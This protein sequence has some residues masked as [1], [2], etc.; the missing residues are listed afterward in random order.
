MN[1]KIPKMMA[2]TIKKR[3]GV[4]RVKIIDAQGNEQKGDENDQRLVAVFS[5]DIH[6]SKNKTI[7]IIPL[8]SKGLEK[9]YIFHVP[10]FFQGK[11]GKAKCEQIRTLTIERFGER[12]GTLTDKEMNEIEDKMVLFLDL[13]SYVRRKIKEGIQEFIKN[14][15]S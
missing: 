13:D 9:K 3:G 2:E 15:Q 12:L 7:T 8:T 10:T 1:E 14:A 11:H 4:Y 6:N 5:N